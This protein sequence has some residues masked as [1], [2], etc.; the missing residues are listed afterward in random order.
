MVVGVAKEFK[1]IISGD[2]LVL[3]MYGGDSI[4][5][6]L[7]TGEAYATLSSYG[8]EGTH[9][10]GNITVF[11]QGNGNGLPFQVSIDL[12]TMMISDVK[13]YPTHSFR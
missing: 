2:G 9:L 1:D 4:G 12:P 3:G 7:P 5:T 11:E 13:Y 10:S 6:D 8:L